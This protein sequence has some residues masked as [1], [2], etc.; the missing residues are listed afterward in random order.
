MIYLLLFIANFFFI[1]LKAFQQRNVGG[2][3]YFA[4]MPTS[5]ALAATEV[6]IIVQV[7]AKGIDLWAM[8][9]LGVAGGLGSIAAV[10]FHRRIFK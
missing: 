5:F 3:H 1:F 8:L 7:V 6:Y 9:A 4:I 10:F 2:A